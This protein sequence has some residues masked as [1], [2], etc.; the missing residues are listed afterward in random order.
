MWLVTPP[1]PYHGLIIL[2]SNVF[3]TSMNSMELCDSVSA[4]FVGRSVLDHNVRNG[5]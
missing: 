3:C 1:S 2:F 5:G 4:Y